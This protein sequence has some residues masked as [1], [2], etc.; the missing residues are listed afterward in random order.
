MSMLV[1]GQGVVH[2]NWKQGVSMSM[3]VKGQ[4]VVIGTPCS[5][6]SCTAT[7]FLCVSVQHSWDKTPKLTL[8]TKTY[9]GDVLTKLDC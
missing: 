4:G 8:L 1:K 9:F 3:L 7:T 2:G 5:Q 6:L